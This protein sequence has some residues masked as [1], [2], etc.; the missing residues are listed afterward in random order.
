MFEERPSWHAEARCNTGDAVLLELFFGH[1]VIG[2][3]DEQIARARQVCALC[4]VSAEC[5][6]A[7]LEAPQNPHGVW[8]GTTEDER[9]PIRRERHGGLGLNRLREHGTSAGY[10]AHLRAGEEACWECRDAH[11]RYQHPEMSTPRRPM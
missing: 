10:Q 11:S 4:P 6:E 5:L 3:T 8:A 2:P 1:M 7:A 9:R